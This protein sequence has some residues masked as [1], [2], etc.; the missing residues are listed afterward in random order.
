MQD[1][2]QMTYNSYVQKGIMDG[3]IQEKEVDGI[4]VYGVR[5]PKPGEEVVGYVN[6]SSFY[7]AETPTR[8]ARLDVDL[9]EEEC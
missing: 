5:A 3:T 4:R 2:Q 7:G 6:L 9:E 1:V 8:R